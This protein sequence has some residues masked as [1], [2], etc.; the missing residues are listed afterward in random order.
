M[1]KWKVNIF[2]FFL[3]IDRAIMVDP[4]P[5]TIA[6]LKKIGIPNMIVDGII[7]THVHANHDAGTF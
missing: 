4:P 7:I 1:D 5:F 6:K 2:N 3:L